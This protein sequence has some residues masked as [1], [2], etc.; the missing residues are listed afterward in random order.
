M[1]G[2][3][4]ESDELDRSYC[5]VEVEEREEEGAAGSKYIKIPAASCVIPDRARA[6]SLPNT[7]QA[8]VRGKEDPQ[9]NLE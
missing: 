3:E 9:N 8:D 2:L 1:N 5:G 6:I 4:W 7:G